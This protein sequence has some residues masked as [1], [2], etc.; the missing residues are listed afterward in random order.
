MLTRGFISFKYKNY[1]DGSLALVL[2]QRLGIQ[3]QQ[4]AGLSRACGF[5][6]ASRGGNL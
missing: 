4:A 5:P 3:D 2:S 1:R 6:C